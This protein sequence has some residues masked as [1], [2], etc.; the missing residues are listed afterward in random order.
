MP[1]APGDARYSSTARR[2]S[3]PM[4]ARCSVSVTTSQCQLCRLLP[5]GACNAMSRQSRIT[6]IGTGPVP[7]RP[8]GP[9]PV[10]STVTPVRSLV[11][12]LCRVTVALTVV[13]SVG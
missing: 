11:P 8:A 12:V 7:V 13:A 5:D 10:Q 6:A 4:A 9:A 2:Y 3:A 1:A